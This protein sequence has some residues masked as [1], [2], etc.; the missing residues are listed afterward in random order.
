MKTMNKTPLGWN[1]DGTFSEYPLQDEEIT[2]IGNITIVR[3]NK[4]PK[5]E[6]SLKHPSVNGYVQ[7]KGID[8]NSTT[9][10]INIINEYYNEYYG[11]RLDCIIVGAKEEEREYIEADYDGI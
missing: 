11:S 1:V 2:T 7:N 4:L 3:N 9:E 5:N 8:I 10:G 6:V